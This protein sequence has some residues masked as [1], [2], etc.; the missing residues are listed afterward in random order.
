MALMI[1]DGDFFFFFFFFGHNAQLQLLMSFLWLNLVCK[2]SFLILSL[3]LIFLAL[4]A[5]I[6]FVE[7]DSAQGNTQTQPERGQCW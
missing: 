1:L 3:C 7:M 5:K 4:F 6:T 2:L